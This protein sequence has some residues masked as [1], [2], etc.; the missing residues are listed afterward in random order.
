MNLSSTPPSGAGKVRHTT[1][2]DQLLTAI[3]RIPHDK[4]GNPVGIRTND[5]AKATG[6]QPQSIPTLLAPHVKSGRVYVCKV[7]AP[8][9]QAQNEYRQGGGVAAPDF[10]PLT[11]KRAG[12]ALGAAASRAT[13]TA[14]AVPLSTPRPAEIP[15]PVFLQP[16]PAVGN[17]LRD[18]ETAPQAINTGSP[19]PE[20]SCR[21]TGA[22]T[23]TAKATPTPAAGVRLKKEP[24][25][26]KA[27]AGNAIQCG[28]DDDGTVLITTPDGF[29][30]LDPK[31]ARKLGHFMRATHDVWNP[32]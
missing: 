23:V 32:F 3:E 4:F 6:I 9:G 16:Q 15:A 18:R 28:I 14:P 22:R 27:S 20:S 1:K 29:L 11:P 8:G 17:A 7:T 24:T 31:Q 13:A 30:E 21:S 5:L 2:T 10:K 26:P 19:R 12:T 25:T